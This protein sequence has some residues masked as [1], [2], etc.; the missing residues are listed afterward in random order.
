[1]LQEVN[2]R[3]DIQTEYVYLGGSLVAQRE[4]PTTGGAAVVKYQHTDALGTPV[5]ETSASRTV[6][7]RNEVEPY[8]QLINHPI[9]DAVG[10]TG[11]V[12]DAMTGLTYMQQRYYDPMI[13]R[14][15]SVDPVT[16]NSVGGN[17]NRYWYGNDNPYRFVDP[18]GRQS[19]SKVV[20][21]IGSCLGGSITCHGGSAIA[22][23]FHSLG[24]IGK[25]DSES[26]TPSSQ[27]QDSSEITKIAAAPA[28]VQVRSWKGEGGISRGHGA[29]G[30]FAP[31]ASARW[32]D[33]T[34]SDRDSNHFAK[35]GLTG[36]ATGGALIGS[37]VVAALLA[38]ETG[39]M[40]LEGEEF[41]LTLLNAGEPEA[42]IMG[43]GGVPG[44]AVGAT[45]GAIAGNA[46]DR[47][48]DDK[49]SDENE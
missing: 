43:A 17:F 32:G 9:T 47:S 41:L 10:F 49:K 29:S 46:Y 36:G 28:G 1:L 14:F 38:P 23:Q 20:P 2:A 11:H 26:S 35:L 34:N 33:G 6:L 45:A 22:A 25:L 5:A 21:R 3:T 31:G 8:G 24:P 18:D 37:L 4:T 13:G 40:S 30:S 27:S 12:Q 16:A 39:G 19:R 7:T 48:Q 15:L 44:G 42:T